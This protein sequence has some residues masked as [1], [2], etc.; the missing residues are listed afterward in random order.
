MTVLAVLALAAGTYAIR[1]AGPLLR[2]RF[3]LPDRARELMSI[4][5]TVLLVA[6]IATS[7]LMDG[8]HFAGPALPIGVAVGGLA[9]WLR[10]PFVLVVIL[11]ASVTALLRLAGVS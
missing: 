9:A 7:S 6:L 2:D 3:T 8:R 5:A 11:A 1:L 10:A 4:A